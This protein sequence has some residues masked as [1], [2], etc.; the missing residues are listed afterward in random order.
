MSKLGHGKYKSKCNVIIKSQFNDKGVTEY[1][2]LI[3]WGGKRGFV[4]LTRPYTARSS[5]VFR[6]RSFVIRNHL[7][8]RCIQ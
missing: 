1:R 8:I 5:A 7:E 4:F 2:A 3:E 6:A